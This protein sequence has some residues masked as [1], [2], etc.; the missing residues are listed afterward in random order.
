MSIKKG[1]II[2]IVNNSIFKAMGFNLV[3]G[4]VFLITPTAIHFK[5]DQT[6]CIELADKQDGTIDVVLRSKNA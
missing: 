4:E 6:R 5:C 1:D 2:E 3:S